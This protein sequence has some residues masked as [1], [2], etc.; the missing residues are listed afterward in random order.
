MEEQLMELIYK[1]LENKLNQHAKMLNEKMKIE[2]EEKM[3]EF[4]TNEITKM[5]G[6][7]QME[8]GETSTNTNEITFQVKF[9][10]KFK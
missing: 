2:F 3:N 7:I 1:P 8:F 6:N 5:I 9:K 10:R 4:A